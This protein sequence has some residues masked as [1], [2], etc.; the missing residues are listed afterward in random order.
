MTSQQIA[1]IRPWVYVGM[2]LFCCAFWLV[3]VLALVG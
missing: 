2:A 3:I 1:R